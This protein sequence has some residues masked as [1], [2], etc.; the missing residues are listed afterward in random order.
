ML[1]LNPHW[2]AELA[3]ELALRQPG[4]PKSRLHALRHHVMVA[5]SPIRPLLFGQL[6]R[7]NL[8]RIM[9]RCHFRRHVHIEIEDHDV[10]RAVF[11]PHQRCHPRIKHKGHKP[12]FITFAATQTDG[13]ICSEE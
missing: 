7:T 4:L 12:W 2:H 3:P 13:G 8:R 5:P 6:Q 10:R 1:V 9:Q 11:G